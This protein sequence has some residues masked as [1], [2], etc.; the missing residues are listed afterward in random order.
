MKKKITLAMVLAA[1]AL[2]GLLGCGSKS[3]QPTTP[4]ASEPAA[5]PAATETGTGEPGSTGD[6]PPIEEEAPDDDA[7][8]NPCG[9]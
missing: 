7:E 4:P 9:N 5:E 3:K 8:A 2:A 6:E 1:L